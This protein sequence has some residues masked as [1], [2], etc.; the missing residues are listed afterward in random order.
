MFAGVYSNTDYLAI[1]KTFGI[2]AVGF[3]DTGDE[4]SFTG[5]FRN[6]QSV[7]G[8]DGQVISATPVLICRTSDVETLDQYKPITVNE[9][10]YEART[11][12]SNGF[13]ITHIAL[14]KV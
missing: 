14:I 4:V 12:I 9:T 10:Q 13:G 5:V 6:G 7:F 3:K 1:L 11:L 8:D 2:K